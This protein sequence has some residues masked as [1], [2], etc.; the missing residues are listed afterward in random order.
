LQELR[1]EQEKRFL[2]CIP[3]VSPFSYLPPTPDP[4]LG[5]NYTHLLLPLA[6]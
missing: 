5:C 1:L 4:S 6:G 3:L 2:V